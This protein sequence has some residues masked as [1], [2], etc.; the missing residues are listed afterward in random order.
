MIQGW[1]GTLDR[2]QPVWSTP[3]MSITAP[4]ERNYSVT[5]GGRRL[6]RQAPGGHREWS[7]TGN[8]APIDALATIAS[9]VAGDWGVGPWWW[10]SPWAVGTNML[11]PGGSLLKHAGLVAGAAVA[12]P[13]QVEGGMWLPCSAVT[14]GSSTS[15]IARSKSSNVVPCPPGEPVTGSLFVSQGQSV[16]IT[17]FNDSNVSVAS[18]TSK[19]A[20]ATTMLQRVSVTRAAPANAVAVRVDVTNA[21]QVA[22]ACV[23]LTQDPMPWTV[24]D[25]CEQAI[26]ESE[27]RDI[28]VITAQPWAN[29]SYTIK[30]VG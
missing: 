16:Q 29:Q 2:M 12:G 10:L 30:E 13:V 11:T 17:F 15:A 22:G 20:G 14:S 26:V 19:P 24:G 3:S 6:V 1:L 8:A 4:V 27:T 28:D 9:F 5:L 21:G 23:T 18:A 25:G 7:M